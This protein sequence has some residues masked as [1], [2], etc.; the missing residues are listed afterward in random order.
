M[1]ELIV[2]IKIVIE[3]D[4]VRNPEI[5]DRI[6][7]PDLGEPPAPGAIRPSIMKAARI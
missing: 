7:A 3:D 5:R 4:R 6:L 2:Q 1:H